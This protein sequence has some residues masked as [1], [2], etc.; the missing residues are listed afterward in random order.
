[1]QDD[2]LGEYVHVHH[3]PALDRLFQQIK[4]RAELHGAVVKVDAINS[5]GDYH[6]TALDESQWAWFRRSELEL[7]PEVNTVAEVLR[8]RAIIVEANNILFGA[9][10]CFDDP[11]HVIECNADTLPDTYRRL[12]ALAKKASDVLSKEVLEMIEPKG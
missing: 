12:A 11:E 2:L 3:D 5:L 9:I 1:M 6:V 8:L 4:D 10:E 7:V